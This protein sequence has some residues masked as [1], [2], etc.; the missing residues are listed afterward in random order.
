MGLIQ[1]GEWGLIPVFPVVLTL[2]PW[3]SHTSSF[4][5]LP[6]FVLPV[7]ALLKGFV[8]LT[9]LL[10]LLSSIPQVASELLISGWWHMRRRW[11]SMTPQ[12]EHQSTW[13]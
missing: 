7:F 3:R 2:L 11:P 4:A 5:C 13:C 6:V 8:I 12:Q 10:L 1:G 9:V